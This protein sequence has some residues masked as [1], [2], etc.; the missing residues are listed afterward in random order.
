LDEIT[1][2]KCRKIEQKAKEAQDA[3]CNPNNGSGSSFTL[4]GNVLFD[5]LYNY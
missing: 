2:T 4:R 1:C 5:D 3:E